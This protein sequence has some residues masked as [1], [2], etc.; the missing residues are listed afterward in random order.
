MRVVGYDV[1]VVSEERMVESEK[2]LEA[3]G[4]EHWVYGGGGG[5]AGKHG[6]RIWVHID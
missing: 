2:G 4:G 6:V 1:E 3:E 5:V